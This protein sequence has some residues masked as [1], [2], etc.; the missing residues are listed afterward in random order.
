MNQRGAND[1]PGFVNKDGKT[2]A[3]RHPKAPKLTHWTSGVLLPPEIE[4]T[5]GTLGPRATW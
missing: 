3:E 1:A 5:P 4:N 2:F